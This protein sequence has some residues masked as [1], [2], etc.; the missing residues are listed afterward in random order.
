MDTGRLSSERA[1][2][3]LAASGPLPPR[4]CVQLSGSASSCVLAMKLLPGSLA[5]DVAAWM[6]RPAT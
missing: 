5:G 2:K 1:L 3:L 4:A 6:M